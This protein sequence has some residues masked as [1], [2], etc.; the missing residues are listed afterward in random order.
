[1]R[2]F[3]EKTVI[4]VSVAA[5]MTLA[6]C[7]GDRPEAKKGELKVI[8]GATVQ[9]LSESD[10]PD[11]AEA[12]GTV[13]ARNSSQI[14]ARLPAT[15]KAVMVRE[16]DR[17]GRGKLLM[18][19]EAAETRAGE[20]GALAAVEQARRGV[21]EART[22]KK[23]ADV[24]FERYHKLF[25][26][27]AVTRQEL[28]SRQADRDM[29]AQAMARAE[30]GLV[31]ASEGARA[32]GTMAGYTRIIAPIS[33]IVTA[34]AVDVG[35]TVFPG[36]PLLTVEE[37]GKYRLEAAAPESL[38]GKIKTGE[39]VTVAMEGGGGAIQGKIAEVVPTSDPSSRTFVVKVDITVKGLRSGMYGKVLFPVGKR[40]GLLIPMAS[41]KE[42]GALT[43][44]W[45]VDKEKIAR[46]RLVKTGRQMGDK[47]EVLSGLTAGENIVTAG[48]ENVVD[49][50]K[51]E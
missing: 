12:V 50:G 7:H 9:L 44:V 3:F 17:V 46:M 39:T 1:M 15:V 48:V 42:S 11:V 27:Q 24:T 35:M 30:A 41:V 4:L 10:I 18:T 43:S 26:E 51:I 21:E 33:G 34:K 49:G 36:T 38:L 5:V 37:E 47:V 20:A 32:A 8:K 40:R 6:A 28:D 22:R 31:Q 23:L 2:S 19:L 13:R 29:A 25:S 16:G 45:V 14:A